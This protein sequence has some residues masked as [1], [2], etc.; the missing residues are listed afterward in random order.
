[1]HIHALKHMFTFM[2]SP[3]LHTH[4]APG[5][6]ASALLSPNPEMPDLYLHSE[7]PHAYLLWGSP[8]LGLPFPKVLPLSTEA[9]G[10]LS[11][12]LGLLRTEISL[13]KNPEIWDLAP[14]WIPT[15]GFW[16]SPFFFLSLGFLI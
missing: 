3:M 11:P 13:G 16:A 15:V 12:S 8:L 7:G 9:V 6:Q 14:G 1:M 5:T 4:Q 10:V 2:L